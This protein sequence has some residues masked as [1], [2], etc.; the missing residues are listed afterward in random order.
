MYEIKRLD[1]D[2]EEQVMRVHKMM[3]GRKILVK[4]DTFTRNQGWGSGVHK[5]LVGKTGVIVEVH[6]S[7]IEAINIHVV[8]D[9]DE[10]DYSITHMHYKDLE[11]LPMPKR[12]NVKQMFDVSTLDV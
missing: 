10:N 9:E 8:V 11:L 7:V 3:P 2:R 1:P 6:C 4:S 5:R 12:K